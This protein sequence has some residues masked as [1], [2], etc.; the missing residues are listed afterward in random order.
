[1]LKELIPYIIL[2]LFVIFVIINEII[3]KKHKEQGTEPK[4]HF[5]IELIFTPRED[6]KKLFND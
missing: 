4:F 6:R 5:W 1:M 2:G 3:E